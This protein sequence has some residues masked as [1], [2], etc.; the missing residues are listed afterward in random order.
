MSKKIL[1]FAALILVSFACWCSTQQDTSNLQCIDNSDC[2]QETSADSGK[3]A[4]INSNL[5]SEN[6]ITVAG[7]NDWPMW[8]VTISSPEW[9]V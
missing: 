3:K 9:G 2:N 8:W 4:Q 6:E 5:E 1:F 7:D